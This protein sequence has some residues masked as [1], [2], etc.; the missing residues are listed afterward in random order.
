[1]LC[2]AMPCHAMLSYVYIDFCQK[3][4]VKTTKYKV[5]PVVT[6]CTFCHVEMTRIP[7]Q[8]DFKLRFDCRMFLRGKS[9]KASEGCTNSHNSIIWL[10]NL[11]QAVLLTSLLAE[12]LSLVFADG[13]KE[14]S[15]WVENGFDLTAV[16]DLG[17][18]YYN[19]C[20]LWCWLTVT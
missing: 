7:P 9:L 8:I 2:H 13:R 16:H 20:F 10:N 5:S 14:T 15:A 12:A 17:R 1:M 6:T 4:P 11:Q 3:G 19:A 18:L